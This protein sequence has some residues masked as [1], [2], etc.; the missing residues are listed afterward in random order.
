MH[1]GVKQT[2]DTVYGGDENE[3]YGCIIRGNYFIG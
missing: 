1:Y 2:Q 3:H